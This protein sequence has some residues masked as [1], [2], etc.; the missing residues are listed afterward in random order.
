[1]WRNTRIKSQ[2]VRRNIKWQSSTSTS[3]SRAAF[4]RHADTNLT[5][6][7]F[8]HVIAFNNIEIMK[9]PV[10][11]DT[12]RLYSSWISNGSTV[13][14]QAGRTVWPA[15]PWVEVCGIID[16][17]VALFIVD[18][19]ER[20]T[21]WPYEVYCTGSNCTSLYETNCLAVP[22]TREVSLIYRPNLE[23]RTTETNSLLF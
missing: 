6:A 15:G 21:T 2:V 11:A 5:H 17:A 8:S 18:R 22:F 3:T 9:L 10:Q 19:A 1:M 12:T 7:T 16:S 23:R 13:S 4:R 20:P 14:T